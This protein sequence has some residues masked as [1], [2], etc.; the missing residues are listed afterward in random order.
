M[1]NPP[2]GAYKRANE[3]WAMRKVGNS[4]ELIIYPRE[5]GEDKRF[6]CRMG[7]NIYQAEGYRGTESS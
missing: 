6:E 2:Q 4:K 5:E 3:R 1:E 7:A